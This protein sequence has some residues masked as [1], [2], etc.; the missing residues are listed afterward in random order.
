MDLDDYGNPIFPEGPEWD[1]IQKEY[2]HKI[3]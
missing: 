2:A 3:N 1:S